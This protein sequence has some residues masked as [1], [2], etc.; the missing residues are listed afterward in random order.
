[1][2]ARAITQSRLCPICRPSRDRGVV[3]GHETCVVAS[4]CE[5]LEQWEDS[6]GEAAEMPGF[7]EL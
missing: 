3:G 1:M 2:K 4:D 5:C 7:C 6:C